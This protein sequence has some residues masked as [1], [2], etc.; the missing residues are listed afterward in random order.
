MIGSTIGHYTILAE[1]GSGGMGVVYRARDERLGRDVA[2]KLLPAVT[3]A[4][5]TARAR[6]LREARTASS[7][8]HPNISTIYE[9]FE[10]AGT[11][12]IAMEMVE[13][14]TL[15]EMI[16]ES[17]L[18]IDAVT[19]YGAQIADALSHAHERGVIHRDLKSANVVITP[20]G[21][22]KVLDFGLAKRV[23]D[24][25][26]RLDGDSLSLTQSGLVV[27]TPPYLAPEVL[28]G[29]AT[30]ARSDI[31]ALG[32]LL[33][34]M[35][36]GRLPFEGRSVIEIATAI[37]NDPAP[38]LPGRVPPGLRATIARCLDKEPGQRY[39]TASEVR[40]SLETAQHDSSPIRAE[41]RAPRPRS[42]KWIAFAGVVAAAIVVFKLADVARHS[43]D[44]GRA[45]RLP[46]PPGS[47]E[48]APAAPVIRALAVL[49]LA[50]L[51]GDPSQ[52]YFADGMTEELI[53]NLA[54]ISSL[55]VI[56]RT[57]V[58]RFKGTQKS[59]PEIARELGVD[60]IVE[61]S[62]LRSGDR[63]RI[64]AQLIDAARD[65]HLWA[66]SYEREL[67][68]IITLQRE[69]AVDIAEMIRAQV[70]PKEHA[71][72]AAPGR[73]VNP[74]ANDLYLKGRF[75][76]G[77]IT[78]ESAVKS[79]EYYKQAIAIDPDDPRFYTGIAD[80]YLVLGQM[81]GVVPLDIAMPEVKDYAGKAIALDSAS[82]EGHASMAAGL[83]FADWDFAGAE[84]EIGRAL[85]LNSGL[86]LSHVIA[87]VIAGAQGRADNAIEYDRRACELDPLSLLANWEFGNEL[88]YA[89]RLDEALAQARKTLAIDSTSVLPQSQVFL[90]AELKGDFPGA[91]DALEKFL[92]EADGGKRAVAKLRGAYAA[93]GAPGYFRAYLD[94]QLRSGSEGPGY[95]CNLAQLYARLG[96]T[97]KAL[98]LIEASFA[99]HEGDVL[100]IKVDPRFASLRQEPRFKELL[101][102]IGLSA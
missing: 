15:R 80:A 40:V 26:K 95:Q 24:G 17:P 33:Y 92:P 31:W 85:E 50:N 66:K 7:L 20:E 43:G 54:P 37:V 99:K 13:G 2:I 100:F 47:A 46:P 89:G 76:W 34:E 98:T 28:T 69:V 3:L 38:P 42:G 14:K 81:F 58:M 97:E 10:E 29:A 25:E 61:G 77:K 70:T 63:V 51:S 86:S 11:V 84:R 56:S 27:G 67:R 83:F 19:R 74:E 94:E 78:P 4:D 64:T 44:A 6:L 45:P 87:A 32:V 91:L 5:E 12:A 75:E 82:A 30:D 93:S 35:A 53:T 62:V 41:V 88:I 21:R 18:P 49:P 79:I 101:R 52:E 60:A 55:K 59:L 1:L 48:P 68:D 90:I 96:E 22:A 23:L 57:S 39:R 73:S 72:M 8:N 102:R 16:A 36:S 9:V 65:Q 71:R